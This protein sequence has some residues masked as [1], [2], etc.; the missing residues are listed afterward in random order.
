MVPEQW[1]ERVLALNGHV[2]QSAAWA[3]VQ[4]RLGF[5]VTFGAGPGWCWLGVLGR[6]G[7]FRYLYLPFGP[8]YDGLESLSAAV[9]DA[10]ARARSMG[11]A[12]VVFEPRTV[13][14]DQLRGLG[15]SK[16]RTRQ[17]EHTMV[18]RLDV[19]EPTLWR[20]VK[21]G[22]RSSI[23][24][25]ERRQLRLECTRDP[26][27]ISEFVR[28]LRETE[29]RSS[30]FTHEQGYFD[31][32]GEEMLRTG[33]A[34]LYFAFAGDDAVAADLLYDFGPT[35]YYAFGATT[36]RARDLQAAP[37]LLWRA[38]LDA[39]Q[40]G[41]TSFDLWGT[42]P[43]GHDRSHGWAGITYFKGAFGAVDRAYAGT[44]E[45]PAHPLAARLHS[46]SRLLRR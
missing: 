6:A 33:D 36:S 14:H 17:H 40:S 13:A 46:V 43:P 42:A 12:S 4:R 1:D 41:M 8:S 45:M 15:A 31:A 27:R 44:W 35:R 23:R 29:Q 3:R 20:G 24:G 32:V 25:A 19:D 10:R 11:C 18:L 7:P 9:S 26:S 16:G 21:S 30:F 2:L 39:R 5:E 22:H 37:A 28:I 34:C 38:M